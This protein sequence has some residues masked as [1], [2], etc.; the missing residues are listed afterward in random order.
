VKRFPGILWVGLLFFS[1][2]AQAASLTDLG[3][4]P[5]YTAS[6]ASA[7]SA[8]GKIIVGTCSKF[9]NGQ[10]IVEPFIWTAA[11]GMVGMGWMP[12]CTNCVA[13]SVSTNGVVVGYCNFANAAGAFKWTAQ[14]G[15]TALSHFVSDNETFATSIS[16]NGQVIVGY[17]GNT[18]SDYAAKW[19]S[20]NEFIQLGPLGS[21]ARDVSGDGSVIV[22]NIDDTA[23][24]YVLPVLWRASTQMEYLNAVAN[25]PQG[26]TLDT[27][28]AVTLDGKF[29][30][31]YCTTPLHPEAYIWS[32][33]GGLKTLGNIDTD[34]Y[35]PPTGNVAASPSPIYTEA[36]AV[37]ENGRA[38]VGRNWPGW[39]SR[40]FIWTAEN[41]PQTI[42]QAL[43]GAAIFDAPWDTTAQVDNY[44]TDMSADGTMIVGLMERSSLGVR[45]FLLDLRDIQIVLTQAGVQL[46]W[47]DGY[48]LQ[49]TTGLDFNTWHDVSGA[50]SPLTISA[51]GAG[52]FYRIIH[53]P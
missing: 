37:A 36:F 35:K 13:T 12:D 29:I 4:L 39:S 5:G 52:S 51:D 10:S 44:T 48:K 11:Q 16:A 42:A 40:T 46:T 47:P 49:Q 28:N 24:P 27:A 34:S 30:A 8:D 33:A 6:A 50:A 25:P 15:Y 45:A 43:A 31:G 1:I 21:K 53:V 41:G 14:S 38:A 22:G 26:F 32:A 23:Y 17:A 2:G 9:E 20:A 19:N 7:I 3:I 18:G